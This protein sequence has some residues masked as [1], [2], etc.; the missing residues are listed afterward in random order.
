MATLLLDAREPIESVQDLLDHKHITT[1][2][3]CDKGDGA[4]GIPPRTRYQYGN[5]AVTLRR[6]W[7]SQQHF[8]LRMVSS[9]LWRQNMGDPSGPDAAPQPTNGR[10][11]QSSA[12]PMNWWQ[13]LIVT[14]LLAILSSIL[15]SGVLTNLFAHKAVNN[16]VDEASIDKKAA[17]SVGKQVQETLG[18]THIGEIRTF[19]FGGALDSPHIQALRKVGWLECAG[20]ELS[21]AQYHLLHDHIHDVWGAKTPGVTFTIPDLRGMFLRGWGHGKGA[22]QNRSVPAGNQNRDTN[23]VGKYQ[24]DG[25]ALAGAIFYQGA[26]CSDHNDACTVVGRP[27]GNLNVPKSPLP[28]ETSPQ[29]VYAISQFLPGSL[30]TQIHLMAA[31]VRI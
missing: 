3:T 23:Q 22:S 15:T 31:G 5:F 12:P 28:A 2:Q 1:T 19:A 24:P 16:A 9:S 30:L 7:Y 27:Y 14:G 26:A 18:A 11:S 4:P 10:L 20:Q 21:V 6:F 25:A 29:N 8:I 13:Y 17:Q